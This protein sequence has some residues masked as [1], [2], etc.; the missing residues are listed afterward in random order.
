MKSLA[1]LAPL[2]GLIWSHRGC[3]ALRKAWLG[4]LVLVCLLTLAAR[5]AIAKDAHSFSIFLLQPDAVLRER[6]PD[7]GALANY[8]KGI[9]K[10]VSSA[11]QLHPE[12]HA[13]GGFIVLAVKPGE[14]SNVWLDFKPALD[15]QAAS[16]IQAAAR[17]VH[18]PDVRNGI[19]VF[20]IRVGLWGG[21]EPA[22]TKPYPAEWQA[23]VQKAGRSIEA[24]ELAEM[25]WHDD[26][27]AGG[28]PPGVRYIKA[29][30]E[31][32][33]STKKRLEALFSRTP[34]NLATILAPRLI[35]APQPWQ[36]LKN[37]SPLKGMKISPAN[38]VL[39]SRNG[40]TQEF[41]GALFQTQTELVAFSAA[42]EKYLSVSGGPFVIRKLNAE[43]IGIY[44]AMIPWDITEPIF[45]AENREHKLVM[46]FT[47]DGKAVFW[48]GDLQGVHFRK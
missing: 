41:E 22:A 33:D 6:V 18:P 44:W 2:Y 5:G 25:A 4:K 28:V 40:R 34:V 11:V 38:M 13:A 29:F 19:V 35:C 1:G 26:P 37:E 16:L 8:V 27:A 9:D 7:V 42:M 17:S 12:Y 20:A 46:H 39:S 31:L 21:T 43:E 36:D 45:V 14:K 15:P 32:N 30:D 24:G 3:P 10:A 47:E 23:E 48:I